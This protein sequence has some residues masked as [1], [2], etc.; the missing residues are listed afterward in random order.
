MAFATQTLVD[1]DF[2]LVTKTT[3]TGTNG[4]ATKIVDVSE[5]AGAATNPRVSIVACQWSVSSHTDIEWDA[6]ANVVALSLNGSGSFNAGGQSLPSIAN[7]AG[8]GVTGDIF[9]ENDAACV[10]TIIL[11]MKKVSGFDGIIIPA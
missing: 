1:S 9:F 4:T 7:N 5:V 10:G 8:S 2:E 11:K 6:T 3:I